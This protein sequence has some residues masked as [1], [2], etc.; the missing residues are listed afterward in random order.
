MRSPLRIDIALGAFV[1][2]AHLAVNPLLGKSIG[3]LYGDASTYHRL[4]KR[5]AESLV[6]G[7]PQTHRA[8]G[9]PIVL[10]VPYRFFG[11][12]PTYGLVLNAVLT[13]L[14]V[15]VLVKLGERLGLT[16]RQARIAA[17]GYGLFPWILVIG[18]TLYSETLFN[19]LAVSLCLIVVKLRAKRPTS[20]W[21]WLIAG[22]VAG[23]AALV[24]PQMALW[25]P[26][27]LV[28]ALGRRWDW[29]AAIVMAVGVVMIISPWAWRNYQRF[30]AFVPLT[31]SGGAS[32]WAANNDLSGP[33][34]VQFRLLPPV[35]GA[36]EIQ[37]D[38]ARRRIALDWIR[39]HPGE[40]AKRVPQRLVRTFDPMSRGDK[41]AFGSTSL[42]WA[43][44]TAWLGVLFTIFLGLLKFHRGRWLAPISFVVFVSLL[45]VTFGG[46]T[47]RYLIP[48]LPFLALWSVV[49]VWQ[50]LGWW[51]R[52]Y[53]PTGRA[54]SG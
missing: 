31:T 14:T 17:V 54:A 46:G 3:V 12:N 38:K 23:C 28:F 25:F 13:G 45:P 26:V 50:I 44:R 42:R 22:L 4:A 37:V 35:A 6:Y 7:P 20:I 15:V 21:W 18:S 11:A 43:V 24:R 33:G 41:G 1:A 39:T 32:L 30:D 8:P 40:F 36:N 19:L 48:A 49:G 53:A 52:T 27:G 2:A 29:K 47:F 10:A 16:V 51:R 9:W 34:L 5:L